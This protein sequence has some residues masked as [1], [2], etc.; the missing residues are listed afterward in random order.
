MTDT[1]YFDTI[2]SLINEYMRN[3]TLIP[4]MLVIPENH[5]L[6]LLAEMNPVTHIVTME[7]L[8]GMSTD[9]GGRRFWKLIVKLPIP[10]MMVGHV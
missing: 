10:T 7:K 1:P 3:N 8:I 5:Y 9:L 2:M 4:N 6:P